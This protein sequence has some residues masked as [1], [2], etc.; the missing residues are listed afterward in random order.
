MCDNTSLHI[1]D[2]KEFKD[3]FRK[4]ICLFCGK[5]LKWYDGSLGYEAYR[6]YGCNLTLDHS[7]LHMYDE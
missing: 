5:K 4:G 2:L 6:C 3:N 7:G 1:A